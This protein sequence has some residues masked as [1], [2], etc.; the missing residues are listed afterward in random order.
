MAVPTRRGAGCGCYGRDFLIGAEVGTTAERTHFRIDTDASALL[1]EARSNVGLVAF[2]TTELTGSLSGDVVDGRLDTAGECAA[3]LVV[4]LASLTS[5]NALY[6]AELYQR[7][8]T[9]RYPEAVAELLRATPL[10]EEDHQLTGQVT[11][12]GVTTVL[13]GDV[14]ISRPEPDTVRVT[15]SSVLDIRDFDIPVPSVLMLR[16]YPDVKV[17]L[18]LVA[19]RVPAPDGR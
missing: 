1:V 15:G 4:P 3:R 10:R 9:R 12:H 6:D 11:I 5:G 8:D 18:Q 2:G 7:L 16:I 14:R 13:D 19:R 17:S